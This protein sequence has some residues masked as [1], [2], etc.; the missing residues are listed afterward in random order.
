M[1][2]TIAGRCHCGNLSYTL[3]TNRRFE[4]IRARACG[5]RFCRVHGA[6]TWSDPAGEATIQIGTPEALQRY[7]FAQRTADYF[8]CRCC[9]AYLGA[10]LSEGD[11]A[12]STLNLRLSDLAVP[13]DPVNYDAED[14]NTKL[15]RR[16][17]MWTPTRIIAGRA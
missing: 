13:E 16:K 11:G 3:A 12:W 5:C 9:G 14:A 15:E 4:D 8:I 17:Q 2:R 1:K 6:G 7:R 10:V